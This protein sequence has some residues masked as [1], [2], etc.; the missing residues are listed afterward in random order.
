MGISSGRNGPA[1]HRSAKTIS[2]RIVFVQARDGKPVA[3]NFE[4]LESQN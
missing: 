2:R 1:R 3:E 4:E